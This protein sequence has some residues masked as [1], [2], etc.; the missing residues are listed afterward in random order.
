[1]TVEGTP[2]KVVTAVYVDYGGSANAARAA[3][4]HAD[5]DGFV[6][7]EGVTTP[8]LLLFA[9]DEAHVRPLA[10]KA[11]IDTAAQMLDA[12]APDDLVAVA[13]LPRLTQ[14]QD[15]TTDRAA[16]KTAL[17]KS[18]GRGQPF[19][20]PMYGL[21]LGVAIE[22]LRNL[23]PM[24]QEV[25]TS[26][27]SSRGAF[28][29][30]NPTGERT[31]VQKCVAEI[32]SEARAIVDDF[33][34]TARD[35]A[36][37]L[38]RLMETLAK[39]PGRKRVV[40]FSEGLYIAP[41]DLRLLARA[42]ELAARAQTT[43]TVIK[44]ATA[45]HEASAAGP[46]IPND[47]TVS[48]LNRGLGEVAGATG[49][50]LNE[51]VATGKP[52]FDRIAR[53]LSGAYTIAFTPDAADRDGKRHTVKV[54]V[55]R[56]GV[57][58]RARREFVIDDKRPPQDAEQ[59][60]KALLAST[61]PETAL[62]LRAA[63]LTSPVSGGKVRAFVQSIVGTEGAKAPGL[64]GAAAIIDGSGKVVASF[65]LEPARLNEADPRAG[66]VLGGAR[67]VDPGEYRLRVAAV[68]PDGRA[69]SLEMA[70]VAKPHPA[71]DVLHSDLLVGLRPPPG[72][73]FRPVPSPVVDR[74]LVMAVEIASDDAD[75]TA[76][77][78]VH[79][80]IAE[81]AEGAAVVEQAVDVPEGR[82]VAT[83]AASL[84]LTLSPGDYVA[85][86][87]VTPPGGDA[88]LLTKGFRVI[89]GSGESARM[90]G[91]RID[92]AAVPPALVVPF[93]RQR[94]LAPDTI[95][96]FLDQVASA[97]PPGRAGEALLARARE[98][99]FEVPA[100]P[101]KGEADHVA[102]SLVRGLATLRDRPGQECVTAFNDLI[103]R[104]GGFIGFALFQGDCYAASGHD[105]DA[106]AAWQMALLGNVGLPV[107]YEQLVDGY[108]RLGDGEQALQALS[109]GDLVWSDRAGFD[110]R[111]GLALALLDRHQEALP[112]LE[113]AASSTA[114]RDVLFA[115]LRSMYAGHRAGWLATAPD[116]LK[117][118]DEY[119]ERY[120][121]AQ[122]PQLAVAREWRKAFEK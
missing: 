57:T 19:T 51:V 18:T 104:A 17:A 59:R 85:R 36:Y 1:V 54:A 12:L 98:G 25:V 62:P 75:T 11:I 44:P 66:L 38:E 37:G 71:G 110:R 8:R 43:I 5:A 78:E 79:F 2:R 4:M 68:L 22:F 40:L 53:E 9:I 69:G 102:Y 86:A 95:S 3:E 106:V 49:G 45:L 72:Q 117:R 48:V 15:F 113:A 14:G 119:L 67:D 112:L 93:D 108:L 96:P 88:V 101:P 100:A 80:E 74:E 46:A 50:T 30:R 24:R 58:V 42:E 23:G 34:L 27:C 82:K 99:K 26:V 63:T 64:A 77:T 61:V 7:N 20:T 60:L 122:G 109:E 115:V 83:A 97:F 31:G 70:L 6:T 29:S 81:S 111:R 33:T 76:G 10:A 92:K 107:I 39:L 28:E 121:A 84:E 55:N 90:T 56:P 103:D 13:R 21:T 16:V 91:A 32:S 114:D 89:S 47:P 65:G 94:A 41:D 118:F 105:R 120:A 73:A 52:L 116:V 87:R 35:T